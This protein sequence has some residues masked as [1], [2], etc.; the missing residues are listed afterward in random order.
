MI[1]PTAFIFDMNGTIIDDMP[2]HIKIWNQVFNEYGA[3]HSLEQSKE[4]L[5]GKNGEILERIFPGKFTD[6]EKDALEVEKE[7]R[8]QQL[9]RNEMKLI[10]GLDNFFAKAWEHNIDIGLGTA[11]IRFNVD[12]ILDGLDIRR[13]FKAI[14]AAEDVSISKPHPETFL[15][16]ASLMNI[17]PQ[18]CIVFEDSPKGVETAANAGMQCVVITTMHHKEEF[19][20]YNN[21]LFVM[22]D[23]TD[24]RLD[25]LFAGATAR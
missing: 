11:A 14:V 2:W 18:N 17:P 4:E 20:Q 7:K 24:E 1:K 13:Y 3:N 8:Y 21:I 5:Y 22:E 19:A 23:Y 6:A 12:F 16:C 25:D 15:K 10:N 9:Y